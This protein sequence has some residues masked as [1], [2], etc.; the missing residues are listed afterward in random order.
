MGAFVSDFISDDFESTSESEKESDMENGLFINSAQA[1]H[2]A[3]E[4]TQEDVEDA[5]DGPSTPKPAAAFGANDLLSPP[6]S[7]KTPP[8]QLLAHGFPFSSPV[9][10][11]A[12]RS[13]GG[14]PVGRA[15]SA[16]LSN[17]ALPFD[18]PP[19]SPTAS[20]RGAAASR[21]SGIRQE[22]APHMSSLEQVLRQ[23]GDGGCVGH[24]AIWA[25]LELL[26][27]SPEM[28]VIDVAY[29]TG[30][31]AD[32][33]SL[34]RH[35]ARPGVEH[36]LVPLHV[37]HAR[38]HWV[39]LHFDL[40]SAHVTVFDSLLES[41]SSSRSDD[42][43]EAARAIVQSLGLDWDGGAWDFEV[44]Q[45]AP[46]QDDANSCG[47]FAVVT[48]V[49]IAAKEPIPSR[50]NA[51]IWRL[52]FRCALARNVSEIDL[53]SFGCGQALPAGLCGA[54]EHTRR[55]KAV[56]DD[57]DSNVG[58]VEALSTKLLASAASEVARLGVNVQKWQDAQRVTEQL[59]ASLDALGS[60]QD[61]KS[62]FQTALRKLT[63]EQIRVNAMQEREVTKEKKLH[64][65]CEV[66]SGLKMRCRI[67]QG[68]TEQ[69]ISRAVDM[70]RSL[71]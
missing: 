37:P 9:M 1:S 12:I 55:K 69:E 53:F 42:Y 21:L 2:S 26:A 8:S 28:R 22:N 29:P 62:A 67:L 4:G 54:V 31:W 19:D 47:I 33:A 38:R 27:S 40:V 36:V 43:F 32:W 61:T 39:L 5:A 13:G 50:I 44:D 11:L 58:L 48:S 35:E 57:L 10:E 16:G 34:R 24:G 71:L 25:L 51:R 63:E 20:I 46:L 15:Y 6:R 49:Y 66:V 52:I 60:S 64:A 14:R 45:R 70:L 7:P 41:R 18:D 3:E 68:T 23:L 17:A 30:S 65:F 59:L 56:L